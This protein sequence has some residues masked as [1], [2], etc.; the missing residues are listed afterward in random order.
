M[1]WIICCLHCEFRMSSE[2]KCF[3]PPEICSCRFL[4]DNRSLNNQQTF[5]LPN[6]KSSG[7]LNSRYRYKNTSVFAKKYDTFALL[8][9]I[10][11]K[12]CHLSHWKK[13]KRADYSML[14]ICKRKSCF[15]VHIS[16]GSLIDLSQTWLEVLLI[17]WERTRSLSQNK[18]LNQFPFK[19][20]EQKK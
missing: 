2:S 5:N 17:A 6:T 11:N 1:N 15:Y 13:E 3:R 10:S 7:P 4:G 14:K 19:R 8:T 12:Q 9:E 16:R 18:V 20:L